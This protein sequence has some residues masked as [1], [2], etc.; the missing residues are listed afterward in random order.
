[1]LYKTVRVSSV[2]GLRELK[3][4]PQPVATLYYQGNFEELLTR[5]RVA[6]VGSR[7]ASPYGQAVT[8]QLATHLSRVG[9]VVISGLAIGVD[10]IAHQAVVEAGGQ[11]IAVLPAGLDKLYPAHHRRLAEQIIASGGA[12]VSEYPMGQGSPM[13]HQF[14]ARNRIIAGLS[15]GVIITEAAARSGSLHTANFALEQGIEV[16]AVPGNITSATSAGTN[17]LIKLGAHP[18]TSIEDI[19][20]VLQITTAAA[21]G[22]QA[23]SDAEAA[24]LQAL[25][26]GEGQTSNLLRHTGLSPAN[27]QQT[28]SMLELNGAVRR[29]GLSAW[30]RT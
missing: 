14:I 27:L 22:Y 23:A 3:Q 21:Q 1:M 26:A 4:L 25:A 9:V 17:N 8:I 28:L 12:L 2:A 6:I 5:P 19:L 10:S 11:T 7:K 24:V 15:R 16:F 18:V 30:A 20:E 29:V 13:K